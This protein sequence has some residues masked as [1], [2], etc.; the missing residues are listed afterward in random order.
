MR[1][2]LLLL[3]LCLSPL[4][5]AQENQVKIH[6]SKNIEFFGYLLELG[7]P[8]ENDPNHPITKVINAHPENQNNPLLMEI[9]TIAADM[10]YATIVNLMYYLPEFPLEDSFELSEKRADELGYDTEEK[11]NL[12]K[13]LLAKVNQFYKESTFEAIWNNLA[14]HRTELLAYMSE[15]KPSQ[16]QMITMES[17]YQS[18]YNHYEIVPSFTIW[19]GPGWGINNGR[20][21]KATF[22]LGPLSKNYE[23][24]DKRRFLHLSIHEFGHSF[25]NHVVSPNEEE[26]EK[27]RGL[28]RELKANM[29]RQ[30]YSDWETCMIE[31]FVRAGEVIIPEL[32]GNT[33]ESKALLK[34][35][36]E[37]RQF[38]YLPFIIKKLKKYRLKKKYTYEEAV[39][40]TLIDLEKTFVLK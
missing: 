2:V 12:L 20:G 10:D 9:F 25:V 17:F 7:D 19:S 22:V 6:F 11:I 8:S 39:K 28:F 1:S 38:I 32:I 16:K 3:T 40:R 29:T 36:V 18:D 15:N 34:N 4:A 35:Y 23:F 5:K 26:L 30:G 21:A 24:K 37:D 27:T 31:H 14:T 33:E 13:K